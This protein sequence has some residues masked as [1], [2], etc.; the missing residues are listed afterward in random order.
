MPESREDFVGMENVEHNRSRTGILRAAAV[1]N[2]VSAP[3]R[4]S[5]ENGDV[6]TAP[7][8]HTHQFTAEHIRATELRPRV[9]GRFLS[10]GGQRF[11][12]KGVTYG[13]FHP[14]A[15][16][17]PFPS[18]QQ[19]RDDFSQMREAGVNTVRL[20]APPPDWL[21]DT[22]AEAGLHLVPDICWGPRKCELDNPYRLEYIRAWT[23]DHARRL[24]N[25]PAMLLYSIGNEIPPLVVRWYG[26]ER[27]EKFLRSLWEI[28]KEES[29]D[30]LVT[31][32]NHPPTEYLHLPFL[33]VVSYNIFLEREPEYRAYLARLINLAGDRPLFLAEIGLDANQH[34]EVGQAKFLDW[35]LRAV[36]EKGLCGAAVYGWT[37]EWG[38][39][40]ETIHGWAFGLTHADRHPKMALPAVSQI[41]HC[42]LY[43][44][45]N[46][47]WPLVSVIVCAYNAAQTLAE[48]LGSLTRLT[49]PRCEIIV[50]DDGSTDCTHVIAESFGIQCIRVPNGGLSLARNIGIDAALGEIVA[51]ID[52]DAFAD[53]DWLYYVVTAL[54]EHDAAAVG[55]PNLSPPSD[56]FIAQ[57]VDQSP[58][59]PTCVLVDN[60]LAEHIPGCNMAYRKKDLC[61]VGQFDPRHRAAGDDVD[62][63]W[64]LLVS[65]R[66]IVYAPSAVVW[67]H[68]R[69]S[70]RGY[71]RQQKGYGFAEAH[72]QRRYPGRF[73]MFGYP[74]WQG[75]VYDTAHTNLRLQGLPAI[76]RP[77]VYQGTFCGAQFQSLYQPFLTWWFQIFTAAEWQLLAGCTFLA[78]LLGLWFDPVIGMVT[79]VAGLAMATLILAAGLLAG[80]RGAEAKKWHGKE[81]WRGVGIIGALH[82]L[83]PLIRMA[84]RVRGGRDLRKD[85]WQFPEMDVL[86]GDLVKRRQWLERLQN[87]MRSCG[88]I[89]QP[90]SQWEDAD[91]DILGPGPYTLKLISVYEENLERGQHFIRYRV[92]A[93]MKLHAPLMV[94]ALMAGLVVL[95]QALYLAPLAVPII[96][97]LRRYVR[98]R[99]M[100]IAAVSQM[101]MECG[102]SIGMPRAKEYSC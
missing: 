49:Y 13:A 41:Y 17:E 62:V 73:N 77:R 16:G 21:A 6:L 97:V 92:T 64:K 54:E 60:E 3:I 85:R 51:F 15:D 4:E 40:D 76:F 33:D 45:R 10:I 30:A 38:I 53:P 68:R 39:F 11:W 8:S 19:V 50:V 94:G 44:M 24:S 34:G 52:S 70:V 100:M 91:L 87:Y 65:H 81:K 61:W 7:R 14:N 86:E 98:A 29:P 66:K 48:C 47:P 23:R 93:R 18:R 101:A 69:G 22:A 99:K 28:V 27:I 84:G 72:L 79:L 88:W 57:C 63:C 20:Y 12:V 59:N 78:G 58:G 2:R 71:L 37:D 75:G 32:V 31:Y 46:K 67:H 80:L 96:V 36:F 25:H 90:S 1:F 5:N 42:D 83:Q 56:G 55:G 26:R 95:T 82:I 74:V 102:W 89:V 9:N 35:Q 43:G